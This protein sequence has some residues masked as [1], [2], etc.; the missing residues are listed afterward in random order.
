MTL[1]KV[2]N[3]VY[4]RYGK[5][6]GDMVSLAHSIV[7]WSF[8]TKFDDA[9]DALNIARANSKII[10]LTFNLIMYKN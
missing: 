3:R 1:Q 8:N 9:I 7:G 5:D 2:A 10:N 6:E 4:K